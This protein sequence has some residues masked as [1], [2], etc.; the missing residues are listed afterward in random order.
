MLQ[1]LDLLVGKVWCWRW[2]VPLQRVGVV[3]DAAG[4]GLPARGSP[5][6]I[7]LGQDEGV[8]ALAVLDPVQ[9]PVAIITAA[10]SAAA[11][12]TCAAAA[13]LRPPPVLPFLTARNHQERCQREPAVAKAGA[14]HHIRLQ[15]S[16]YVLG[17]V[18]APLLLWLR[19]AVKAGSD[20]TGRICSVHPNIGP[21]ASQ[22]PLNMDTFY[23]LQV[24]VRRT[25]HISNW[26]KA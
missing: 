14:Q 10:T 3:L 12:A 9:A 7:G 20:N 1:L 6:S 23:F 25:P 15:V 24:C 13:A 21:P 19:V 8:G 11:A 2:G 18:T 26:V 17:S 4:L 22:T 16:F 5:A